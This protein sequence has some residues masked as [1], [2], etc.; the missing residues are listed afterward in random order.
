MSEGVGYPV[1]R[2]V[3]NALEKSLRGARTPYDR[4]VIDWRGAP[5]AGVD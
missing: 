5:E 2:V 4:K 3:A 1:N